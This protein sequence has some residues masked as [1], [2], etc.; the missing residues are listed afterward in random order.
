M[1]LIFSCWTLQHHSAAC[2]NDD[3]H[4]D[5]AFTAC[6]GCP[7]PGPETVPCCNHRPSVTVIRPAE[8]GAGGAHNRSL[9][10]C[11]QRQT[12]QETPL[13]SPRGRSPPP[14]NAGPPPSK[15]T[16]HVHTSAGRFSLTCGRAQA[17][18]PRRSGLPQEA[19]AQPNHNAGRGTLGRQHPHCVAPPLAV[20]DPPAAIWLVFCTRG[21]W[22]GIHH[23]APEW[24][25]SRCPPSR[26]AMTGNPRL[27]MVAGQACS[28]GSRHPH[29]AATRR[30][31]ILWVLR[32]PHP[33][34]SLR[35]QSNT[36]HSSGSSSM[37]LAA[38]IPAQKCC[39]KHGSPVT[40]AP[41][42]A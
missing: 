21:A 25:M 37:H 40:P 11:K 5:T 36:Q 42:I 26:R 4:H 13:R 10:R 14:R 35:R 24:R 1:A 30:C 8:R 23:L 15:Q 38:T 22:S 7:S 3:V 32:R 39:L 18:R 34:L 9:W 29:L 2:H 33:A 6:P 27:K 17:V 12:Q 28:R 31:H 16:T 20:G 41:R 19:D